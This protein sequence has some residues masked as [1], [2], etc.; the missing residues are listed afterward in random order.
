M[1]WPLLSFQNH[2]F[3]KN[4][5]RNTASVKRFAK[6]ISTRQKLLLAWKELNNFQVHVNS[7]EQEQIV[8]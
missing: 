8:M 6:V 4:A 7:L 3:F 2:F 5:L 1:L